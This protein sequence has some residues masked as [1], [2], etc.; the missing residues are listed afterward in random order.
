MAKSAVLLSLKRWRQQR[1]T[2]PIIQDLRQRRRS[3]GC[4]PRRPGAEYSDCTCHQRQ[5]VG[6]R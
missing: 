5:V 3:R 6:L 4:S 2:H 1:P